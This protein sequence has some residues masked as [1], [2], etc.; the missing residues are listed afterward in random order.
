MMI[1]LFRD[2]LKRATDNCWNIGFIEGGYSSVDAGGRLRIRW[3]KH[4]EKRRWFADPF[5]LEV[6]D[7][8]IVVLVEEFDYERR[9][10]RIAQLKVDRVSYE[11]SSVKILLELETHLS[12]PFIFRQNNKVYVIPENSMS[13]YLSYY[14]YDS[15]SEELIKKGI[16]IE[17]PLTD[18]TV[19]E[20]N[21]EFYLISTQLP[22]PNG[23]ILFVRKL[24]LMTFRASKVIVQKEFLKRYARNAGACFEYRGKLIRPAQDCSSKY[25]GGVVFQVFSLLENQVIEEQID[26]ALYPCSIKYPDGL[27]TFNQY[28][29]LAVIDGRR[30]RVPFLGWMIKKMYAL[31]K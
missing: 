17:A 4:K 15:Q 13:G 11:L 30:C 23:N 24:N 21:K 2:T 29:S 31:V 25:G 9:I 8:N 28:E 22:D 20:Y 19:L 6:N 1:K 16:I 12:F 10:G 27:H 14:E 3:M 7:T 26:N 18:A 5:I